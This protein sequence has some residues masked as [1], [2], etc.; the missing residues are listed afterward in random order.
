VEAVFNAPMHAVEF[1]Y[2]LRRGFVRCQ[3]GDSICCFT[4]IFVRFQMSHFTT[5]T[6]DLSYVGEV[7]IVVNFFTDPNASGF[8]PSVILIEVLVLRGE[9]RPG[10]GLLWLPGGQ[11]GFLL[12]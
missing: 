9:K 8:D 7:Y 2:T 10:S 11:A 4:G 3:A 6:K 12:P 5:D 1:Q